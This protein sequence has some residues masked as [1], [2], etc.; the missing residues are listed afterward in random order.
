[1]FT[2]SC[3]ELVSE[4]E[5]FGI[6]GVGLMSFRSPTDSIKTLKAKQTLTVQNIRQRMQIFITHQCLRFLVVHQKSNLESKKNL[7]QQFCSETFWI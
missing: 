6:M 5:F 2:A 4:I 3:L 7:I 1:M